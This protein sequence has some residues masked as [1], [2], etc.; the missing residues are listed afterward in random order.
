M[1]AF[2]YSNPASLK[3]A[4]ALWRL[5]G[6]RPNVLAGGTDLIRA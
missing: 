6:A 1:Q 5:P 4:T 2:E 3:E